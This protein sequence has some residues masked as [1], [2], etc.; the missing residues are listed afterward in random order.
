MRLHDT[1][2]NCPPSHC[3]QLNV[4]CAVCSGQCAF[5]Q[6]ASSVQCAVCS[7]QYAVCSVHWSEGISPFS[8]STPLRN[9]AHRQLVGEYAHGLQRPL[10]VQL[11]VG[12]Q[13][14]EHV[15]LPRVR[16]HSTGDRDENPPKSVV[17]QHLASPSTAAGLTHVVLPQLLHA[18]EAPIRAALPRSTIRKHLYLAATLGVAIQHCASVAPL[19]HDHGL[20]L[21]GV[22]GGEGGYQR[23]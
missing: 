6:C 4:Q 2:S 13:I 11:V 19:L 9:T 16:I 21:G 17:P 3:P 12:L 22:S 5:V 10:E 7:V 14:G 18:L 8:L 23:G 1:A 15:Q 20:H